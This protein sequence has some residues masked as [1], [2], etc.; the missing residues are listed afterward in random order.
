MIKQIIVATITEVLTGA[1]PQD[2]EFKQP[3][4]PGMVCYDHISVSTSDADHTQIKVGFKNGAAEV[5]LESFVSTVSNWVHTTTG[6]V[7][8]P[9]YWRP[10]ARII[11][12][13]SGETVTIS[14]LGYGTDEKV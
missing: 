5:L 8:M 6:R 11:S 7:F 9:G 2:I 10:F 3:L 12:G 14:V 4:A 13:D 1:D